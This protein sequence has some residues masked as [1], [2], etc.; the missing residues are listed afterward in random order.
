MTG[1]CGLV[2]REA[3][4]LESKA[5]TILSLMEDRG[6]KSRTFVQSLPDREKIAIGICDSCGGQ[7][8]GNSAI[9]LAL[10]GVFFSED[11]GYGNPAPAGP[12][13]LIRT[14]GAFAFL[15]SL[16]DHLIADRKSTRLNSSHSQ[17]SYAVFCLKKK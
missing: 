12:S 1:I 8:F 7:S 9:A 14:A 13:R 16:Q 15:A 5:K 6:L 17:I 11:Q 3:D 10:D 4:D 2:G